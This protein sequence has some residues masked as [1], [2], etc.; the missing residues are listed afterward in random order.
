MKLKKA[1]RKHK[2]YDELFKYNMYGIYMRLVSLKKSNR[3]H[4]K[5]VAIFE[6]NDG[7]HKTIHFGDSRYQDYTQHKDKNRRYAYWNRHINEINQSP[8]TAGILSLYILWG[9][10]TSIKKNIKSYVEKFGL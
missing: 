4:K 7:R 8:D 1:N 5:Y 10:S 3:K 2:K 9:D 6:Y